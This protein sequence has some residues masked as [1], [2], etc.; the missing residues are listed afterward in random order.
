MNLVKI[1]NQYFDTDMNNVI[2]ETSTNEFYELVAHPNHDGLWIGWKQITDAND[3]KHIN[4][5]IPDI[6]PKDTVSQDAID[7]PYLRAYKLYLQ[8]N[9]RADNSD[10]MNE[11]SAKEYLIKRLDRQL[12]SDLLYESNRNNLR[13]KD[14][15][16]D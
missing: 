15:D 8:Y 10:T 9:N 1:V 3:I 5:R 11:K 7:G 16:C 2:I 12:V 13:T 4:N 14:I 6:S